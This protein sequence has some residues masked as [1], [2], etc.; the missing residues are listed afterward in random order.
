MTTVSHMKIAA[1]KAVELDHMLGDVAV[2]HREVMG[3]ET[4][5]FLGYFP[6]GIKLMQG[7]AGAFSR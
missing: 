3:N 2:Q 1:Y 7:G 4:S 6:K 5:L